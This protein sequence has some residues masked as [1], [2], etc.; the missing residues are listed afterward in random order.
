MAAGVENRVWE[1]ADILALM[2]EREK[3]TALTDHIRVLDSSRLERPRMGR[4]SDTAM[5]G[6]E[7]A[8]AFL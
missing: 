8:L 2:E 7:L 4:V 1:I 3:V 6:L 5:G